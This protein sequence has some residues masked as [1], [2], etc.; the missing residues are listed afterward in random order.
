MQALFNLK[1][2]TILCVVS[3]VVL[4]VAKPTWAQEDLNE[5]IRALE[6]ELMDLRDMVN[7]QKETVRT[8]EQKTAGTGDTSIGGYGELNYANFDGDKKDEFDVQRFIMFLGHKFS[9]RTR[10][11]SE[12][13]FEH[14]QVKGGES[15]GEVAMEQAYI[16]HTLKNGLNFRAGLQIVPIGLINEYHEPP[17]FYGMERNNIETKIIPST[18]REI[19]FG[20]AGSTFGGLDYFAGTTTTPDASKFTASSASTGFKKMRVSGK[21][22]TANDMGY[23]AGF[24]YTGLPGLK[25]GGTIWTGNTAQDGQG[26]GTDAAELANVDARLTI[27]DLHAQYDANDWKLTALYAAGTLGDTEAINASASISAGSDDAAPEEFS[28]WYVEAGYKGLMLGDYN[29]QP[30]YRYADYN[31]QEKVAAGFTTDPNN[32]DTVMTYGISFYLDPDVVLKLDVQDFDNNGQNDST[33][34]GIGWM[35]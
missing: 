25:W 19:G 9:D 18:W 33:N 24:N 29:I 15:G 3:A 16:E 23:Y 22:V 20:F 13:E 28:G 35:F 2:I 12:I 10:M 21:Q 11:M 4:L 31:T 6:E 26:K 30:F 8:I 5:R 7:A 32:A 14:A 1:K 34:I 17:V 27:W